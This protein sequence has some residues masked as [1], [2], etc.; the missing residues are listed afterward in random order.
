MVP[1]APKV[2]ACSTASTRWPARTP[3]S[4][5]ATRSAASAIRSEAS[6]SNGSVATGPPL[7]RGATRQGQ[8]LVWALLRRQPVRGERYTEHNQE[9]AEAAALRAGREVLRRVPTEHARTHHP[10]GEE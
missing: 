10:E 5:P 9:H 6:A 7:P 1:T 8:L 2:R 4:R 3:R